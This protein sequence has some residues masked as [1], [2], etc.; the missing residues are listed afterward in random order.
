MS[1]LPAIYGLYSSTV[2]LFVYGALGTSK[3]ISLG[4]MAITSLLVSSSLASIGI[5]SDSTDT[6]V[7]YAMNLSM[8]FGIITFLLGTFR[9]GV[10]SNFLSTSVLSGFITASALVISLSQLKYIL[11]ITIPRFQYSHQTI[12]YLLTHLHESNPYAV[13]LGVVSWIIL[14]LIKWYKTSHKNS[15]LSVKLLINLSSLIAII[16]GSIVAFLIVSNDTKYGSKLQIIG[17]IPAGI[18]K[19][20]FTFLPFNILIELIPHAFLIAL[21]SFTGNWAVCKKYGSIFGYEVDSN[22]ELIAYG[23]SS[24]FAVIFHGYILSGGLAR[25]SVNVEAGARTLV[26]AM[27]SGLLM[28]IALLSITKFFYYIPMTILASIIEVSVA[29]MIDVNTLIETYYIDK[30]DFIVMFATSICTFFVGIQEGLFIGICCSIAFV[31][32]ASSF[33]H[34][35]ILGR[36]TDNETCIYKDILRYPEGMTNYLYFYLYF[37]RNTYI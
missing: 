3:H 27:I 7:T 29:S 21:I 26:A 6:Y 23:L 37:Y 33:P 4:P 5:S 36:L 30:H 9:L 10:L 31:I 28:I 15:S 24:M 8:L 19:P 12:I 18:L 11:G 32:K 16:I 13:T 25:T 1:G 17:S 22:Q 34:I 14:Y 20:G 2:G 35:A